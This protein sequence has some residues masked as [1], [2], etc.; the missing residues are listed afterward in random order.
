MAI[1]HYRAAVALKADKF[2]VCVTKKGESLM[3]LCLIPP[4]AALDA[5]WLIFFFFFFLLALVS[6]T[7]SAYNASFF[8]SG[9]GGS[10]RRAVRRILASYTK[11]HILLTTYYGVQST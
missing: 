9:R 5:A 8:F 2:Q 10:I 7:P 3:P 6:P 11:Y 4:D 1:Q